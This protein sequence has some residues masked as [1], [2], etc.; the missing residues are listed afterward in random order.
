YPMLDSQL[1]LQ[2]TLIEPGCRFRDHLLLRCGKRTCLGRKILNSRSSIGIDEGGQRLHEMPRRTVDA[3]FIARM[4]ILLGSTSPTL[5]AGGD[6]A[7][8]D[9]LR[10]QRD[11][12]LAVESLR[13]VWHEDSG[14]LLERGLHVRLIHDLFEMR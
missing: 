3:S 2:D 11:R 13:G 8:D 7:F 12:D 14:T 9:A 4:D 10:S 1:L 5:A 6:F